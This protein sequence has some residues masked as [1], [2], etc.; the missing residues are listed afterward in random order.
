MDWKRQIL[1]AQTTEDIS[2]DGR[3]SFM[4]VQ[5][6]YGEDIPGILLTGHQ[7]SGNLYSLVRADGLW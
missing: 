7:G 5:I 3:E 1:Q 2:F 4:R 6:D